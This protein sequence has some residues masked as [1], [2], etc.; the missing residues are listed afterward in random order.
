MKK[1]FLFVCLLI[2]LFNVRAQ[3]PIYDTVA[4]RTAIN[5]DIVPNASGGI[6]ATK[7]NRLLLGVVNSMRATNG[8]EI[9]YISTNTFT[10]LTG[11]TAVGSPTYSITG[12]KVVFTGAGAAGAYTK[13]IKN[14]LGVLTEQNTLQATITLEAAPDAASYGVAIGYKSYNTYCS[15][16]SVI[17][18][19]VT[20]TGANF[21]KLFIYGD[22]GPQL[23]YGPI[24]TDLNNG[25]V[26]RVTMK[27]NGW[28]WS[29]LVQNFTQGWEERMDLETTDGGFVPLLGN[30]SANPSFFH[31]GGNISIDSFRYAINAP[32]ST[33]IM[34]EG[35][36]IVYGQDADTQ[37]ERLV[38]M[39]GNPEDN[40]FSGGGCDV[41][42][43]IIDRLP[44][45]I[46]I[47]PK[48]VLLHDIAG[49]DIAQAIPSGTWQAN[50]ITIRNT[51]VAAGIQVI[52][53]NGQPRTGLDETQQKTFIETEPTFA[54]DFIIDTWTPMLGTGTNPNPL[55]MSDATHPNNIGMRVVANAINNALGFPYVGKVLSTQIAFGSTKGVDTSSA[56]LTFAASANI[57]SLDSGAVAFTGETLFSNAPQGSVSRQNT[58]LTLR[59]I[60]GSGLLY[61]FMLYDP[62]G[63]GLFANTAGTQNLI[64]Q[65]NIG[66]GLMGIAAPTA[67]LD[68]GASNTSRSGLRIRNGAAPSSPNE[69]D[70]WKV[71]DKFYGVISTGVVAKEFTMNNGVLTSGRIPYNTTNGRLADSSNLTFDGSSMGLSGKLTITGTG[72]SLEQTCV[73]MITESGSYSMTKAGYFLFL[74]TNGTNDINFP[75]PANH[76]GMSIVLTNGCGDEIGFTGSYIPKNAAGTNDTKILDGYVKAYVSEY[77]CVADAYYWR[78]LY[79]FDGTID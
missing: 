33:D 62:A 32:L 9:P 7:L 64:T 65:F 71:T 8:R 31:M 55:L 72:L 29:L 42:Q 27:N 13:Y 19:I 60:A 6:T 51:I 21:G 57:M 52:W 41:T 15:T 17:G 1:I 74:N 36:S 2:S 28:K 63:N 58:G 79:R 12:G 44:E 39:V 61:N 43:S 22:Y 78:L 56:N 24:N 53:T 47:K 48:R 16:E 40:I 67:L 76:R 5:T 66:A 75:N 45:I 20:A 37:H 25:D 23:N 10:S 68:V 26:I 34:F 54:G 50:L 70:V 30:N 49:N 77:D 69:G 4:L 59:G 11:Y 3:S 46:A 73:N 14:N 35:N 38:N 18:G